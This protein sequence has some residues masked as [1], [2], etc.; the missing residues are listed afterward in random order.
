MKKWSKLKLYDWLNI[1]YNTL[2]FSVAS[3][4][5]LLIITRATF[6]ILKTTESSIYYILTRGALWVPVSLL[7][8][9]LFNVVFDKKDLISKNTSDLSTNLLYMFITMLII[10][11]LSLLIYT[12]G[13]EN[14]SPSILNIVNDAV[15]SRI[16]DYNSIL[17]KL[18]F[19][20]LLLI[21]TF[22]NATGEELFIRYIAYKWLAKNNHG[23]KLKFIFLITTSLAFGIYHGIFIVINL[24]KILGI[25]RFILAFIISF[26]I[27]H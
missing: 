14:L 22:L 15:S 8:G 4:I 20:I 23:K 21:A 18:S 27:V 3:I 5:I 19:I 11:P 16:S 9:L 2:L 12:I 10:V 7:F 17:S 25:T 1:L 24:S 6:T 26:G 13:L